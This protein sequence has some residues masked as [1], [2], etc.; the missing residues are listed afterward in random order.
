MNEF[1]VSEYLKNVSI[2]DNIVKLPEGQ[3]SRDDYL[4][5][6]KSLEGIGGKWKGGKISGFVFKTNPSDLLEKFTSG[7]VIN[8]K[9]EFQFFATPE[10]IADRMVSY[11]ELT[12]QDDI[13]EPS[14]GQGA[15]IKAINK[16]CDTIPDYFELMEQNRIIL[17]ESNARC[18]IV[19][20]NFLGNIAG[21]L[22]SKI[23]ANPPFT[24]NQDIN[25]IYQMY[26][27]LAPGGR[28]VTLASTHWQISQNKKETT[29]RNWLIEK[30]A[31][32]IR[33][34]PGEFKESGTT[35]SCNIIIIDKES[36]HR[37]VVPSKN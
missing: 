27:S 21:K 18:Q 26:A 2:E 17:G 5:V 14:A 9:K 10:K 1:E 12:E 32:I 25:H 22:Y 19:G 4:K 23:I 37:P 15:I 30:K 3:L 13:L 28:L 29:F 20:F 34:E 36:N 24:K 6:K 35:V 31:G 8:L 33:I 7:E 16:V 11:A